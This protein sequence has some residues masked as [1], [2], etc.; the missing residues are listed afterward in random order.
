MNMARECIHKRTINTFDVDKN[1]DPLLNRFAN[2]LPAA[3]YQL[4]AQLQ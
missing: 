3:L 2:S 4:C 1:G